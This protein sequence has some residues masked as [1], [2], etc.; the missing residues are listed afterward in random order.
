MKKILTTIIIILLASTSIS[1]AGIFYS[2]PET[3]NSSG[4]SGG[5]FNNNTGYSGESTSEDYGGFFRSPSMSDPG[6]R[7]G[8]GDGIGQNAPLGD[9][10]P[11]II[12]CCIAL[13]CLRLFDRKRNRRRSQSKNNRKGMAKNKIQIIL[14]RVAKVLPWRLE[15]DSGLPVNS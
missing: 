9:G 11:V 5:F 7:P 10:W 15:F 6:G 4:S 12:A 1:Y 3:E 8:S 2:Q 14:N 13:I